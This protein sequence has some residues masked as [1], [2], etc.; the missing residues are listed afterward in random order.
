MKEANKNKINVNSLRRLV[1]YSPN[2]VKHFVKISARLHGLLAMREQLDIAKAT[3]RFETFAQVEMDRESLKVDIANSAAL[4]ARTLANLNALAKKHNI[5]NVCYRVEEL[6]VS[7]V[8]AAVNDYVDELVAQS[9][10]DAWVNEI[11]TK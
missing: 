8:I 11:S 4:C 5:P 2:I 1:V 7:E 3:K 10:Y 9:D 6:S